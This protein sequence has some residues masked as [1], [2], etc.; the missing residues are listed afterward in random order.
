MIW[1]WTDNSARD[2]SDS[3]AFYNFSEEQLGLHILAPLCHGFLHE[4]A[5]G[6][7]C[8]HFG[9]WKVCSFS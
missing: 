6:L 5:H 7:T 4:T 3:F 1:M 9:A 8:K 2:L